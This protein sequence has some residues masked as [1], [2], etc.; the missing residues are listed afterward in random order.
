[1]FLPKFLLNFLVANIVSFL[2]AKV[3]TYA[4]SW[5]FSEWKICVRVSCAFILL[6]ES[7][8]IKSCRIGIVIWVMMETINWYDD[9]QASRQFH[10]AVRYPV[11]VFASSSEQWG[12][13]ILPESLYI[14]YNSSISRLFP[15]RVESANYL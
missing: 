2:S 12:W 8:G 10:I 1:M 5:P 15:T 4:I 3:N 13:R 9:S 6:R 7:L 14:I 11:L